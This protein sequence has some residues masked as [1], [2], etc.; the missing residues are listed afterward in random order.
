[1]PSL[2]IK[3]SENHRE[4]IYDANEETRDKEPLDKP[5]RYIHAFPQEVA[6]IR[7][8]KTEEVQNI[9]RRYI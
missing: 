7:E 5:F 2:V 9:L 6:R 4:F 3:H 1:M 8:A